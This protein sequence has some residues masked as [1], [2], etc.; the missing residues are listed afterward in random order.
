LATPGCYLRA[1]VTFVPHKHGGDPCGPGII[2]EIHSGP[3]EKQ[4]GPER[5]T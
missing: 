5:I 3:H 4:F 1:T 2:I